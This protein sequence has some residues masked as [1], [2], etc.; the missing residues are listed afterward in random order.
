MAG[1]K[2]IP[3]L[4]TVP[5]P[6][7]GSVYLT[8][9]G[10]DYKV[11]VG[12]PQGLAYLGGTG[13]LPPEFINIT[14]TDVAGKPT[15]LAG[16]NITAVD[17]SVLTGV[18]VYAQRW[19]TW[20]EVTSKPTTFT[21][22]AHV[23]AAA[24]VTSGIFAAARLGTGTASTSTYLRGDGQWA[25]I[26]GVGTIDWSQIVNEPIYT[27]RWASWTEITSKP[28]TFPP[29][30]HNH[31]WADITG[32]PVYTTR[33][34]TWAEVTSKPA[35]GSAAYQDYDVGVS[36]NSIV[37]RDASGDISVR[38]L[39]SEYDVTSGSIGYIMTQVDTVSNNFVRPSTPLQVEAVLGTT[40]STANRLAKRDG[41]GDLNAVDFN[42]TSDARLKKSVELTEPRTYLADLLEFVSFV[43]KETDQE[44]LG[45]IAQQVRE[46]APE[47]V[48]TDPDGYLSIDKAS[49]V[50][51]VAL[52]L[53]RR[54]EVLETLL[55][56]AL[57][58]EEE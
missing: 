43:W 48:K 33:W 44:A 45:L 41:A 38:L 21:P 54:V 52:G 50:L 18:P 26:P 56:D 28:A 49:L 46:V 13:A 36:A 25:T 55:L 6:I 39:R 42:S 8:K 9:D 47:Y 17:W 5:S 30:G 34:P 27:Q 23:H 37:R 29:S 20:T 7:G 35:F 2:A 31:T 3:A 11:E 4:P 19:P 10:E 57:D 40:T 53:A 32:E 24:D 58:E 1:N 14:W 22:S 15:T 12:G 16:Y 51:E